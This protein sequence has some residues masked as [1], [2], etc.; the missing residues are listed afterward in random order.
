MNLYFRLRTSRRNYCVASRR[1]E[2][3][4]ARTARTTVAKD[5]GIIR[6]I[7]YR[8]I[9]DGLAQQGENPFFHFQIRQ[10]TPDRDT[11]SQDQLRKIEDLSL[12]EGSRLWH[13]RSYFLFALYAAGVRFKDVALMERRNIVQNGD[14]SYT[15]WRVAYQMSKTG[16]ARSAKLLPPAL[17]VV[18]WY[19]IPI[20]ASITSAP[21]TSKWSGTVPS[22]PQA[23]RS[24]STT[25]T[26][27]YAA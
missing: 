15:G 25:K 18:R 8:A 21:I 24:E 12:E 19:M 5:L 14:E 16:R 22:T 2:S 4:N 27:P 9:R 17:R 11:L 3:R 6:A 20:P 26:P 10:G 1:M 7:F 23:H 13:A